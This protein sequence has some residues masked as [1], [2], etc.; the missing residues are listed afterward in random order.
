MTNEAENPETIKLRD[1][2]IK[3]WCWIAGIAVVI[4]T[5]SF[6]LGI[7]VSKLNS[8]TGPTVTHITSNLDFIEMPFIFSQAGTQTHPISCNDDSKDTALGISYVQKGRIDDATSV[9]IQMAGHWQVTVINKKAG[10]NRVD[11]KLWC[12]LG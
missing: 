12:E 2:S 11:V 5:T 4:A 7:W 1:L 10:N 9:S 3:T 8:Q 6:G